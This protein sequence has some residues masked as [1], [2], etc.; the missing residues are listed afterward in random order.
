MVEEV[1]RFFPN[2]PQVVK[3]LY[4][5]GREVEGR[6]GKQM[7]FTWSDRR[8]SFLPLEVG[9]MIDNLGV[10]HGQPIE[11]CQ[12]REYE[13]GE[14]VTRWTVRLAGDRAGVPAEVAPSNGARPVEGA[15]P[16]GK[17]VDNHGSAAG[18]GT[19]DRAFGDLVV[20]AQV[21]VRGRCAACAGNGFIVGEEGEV[22]SCGFCA[23]CG[24]HHRWIPIGELAELLRAS[25]RGKAG[26]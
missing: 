2:V 11:I 7:M 4:A 1:L 9:A 10:S 19:V 26:G 25:V 12:R 5:K 18:G 23:G 16:G 6:G 3:M 22:L 15:C 20:E 8:R 21:Q 17:A 13:S 14:K 24:M